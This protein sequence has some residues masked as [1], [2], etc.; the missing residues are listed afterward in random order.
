[1]R[2][3]IGQYLCYAFLK[4]R[5]LISQHWAVFLCFNLGYFTASLKAAETYFCCKFPLP[6]PVNHPLSIVYFQTSSFFSSTFFSS[7]NFTRL[8]TQGRLCQNASWGNFVP[9]AFFPHSRKGR[10]KEPEHWS[11]TWHPEFRSVLIWWYLRPLLLYPCTLL[12]TWIINE[13]YSTLYRFVR[14]K[15]SS[16]S[17]KERS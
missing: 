16:W 14:V 13:K 17:M 15:H 8:K 1:M 12:L 7:Q 4:S 3:M 6:T 9:T 5:I 2:A 11:V 10:E